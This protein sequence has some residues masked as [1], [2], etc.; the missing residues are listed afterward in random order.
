MF[1]SHKQL[2]FKKVVDSGLHYNLICQERET[3]VVIFMLSIL[4]V[5]EIHYC[6][7]DNLFLLYERESLKSLAWK[8]DY[9]V[10]CLHLKYPTGKE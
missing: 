8:A 1:I 5:L 2:R 6:V 10:S 7:M 3:L 4:L 9:I